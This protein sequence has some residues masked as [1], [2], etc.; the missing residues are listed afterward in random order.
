MYAYFYHI[1]LKM[2]RQKKI[3]K[4]ATEH[5]IYGLAFEVQYYVIGRNILHEL[6]ICF[7]KCHKKHCNKIA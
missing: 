4:I 1:I 7:V 3:C 5:N 2:L 6:V